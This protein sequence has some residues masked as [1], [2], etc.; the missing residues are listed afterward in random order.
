MN[1]ADLVRS[2]ADKTGVTQTLADKVLEAALESVKETLVKGEGIRLA[3][4]ATFDVVRTA[5]RTGRIPKTGETVAIPSRLK[6]RFTPSES[7]KK[8]VNG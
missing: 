2:I 7:L 3:G 8:A 6:V 5:P 1:K 4:F